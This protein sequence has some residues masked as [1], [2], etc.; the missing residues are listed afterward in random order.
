MSTSSKGDDPRGLGGRPWAGFTLV[1]ALVALVVAGFLLP[2]L[3]RA[4]GG[5]WTATRTPLEVVSAMILARDVVSG[6]PVPAEAR[7]LGFSAERTAG[8]VTVL[9]LP[10]DVAPAPPGTGKDDASAL[11]PEATP[12]A[13][14]LAVPKGFG[15]PPPGTAPAANLRLR[16]VSATVRTPS[17]RRMVLDGV[18]LDDGER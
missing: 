16:R 18:R 11:K 10:S 5:A 4:L 9:V 8:A 2:S 15:A 14:R 3:A 13:I 1:E 17:G 12:S 7:G 6:D